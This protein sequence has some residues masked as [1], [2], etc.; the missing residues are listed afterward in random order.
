MISAVANRAAPCRTRSKNRRSP[1]LPGLKIALRTAHGSRPLRINLP[2]FDPGGPLGIILTLFENYFLRQR[3]AFVKSDSAIAGCDCSSPR[4]QTKQQTKCPTGAYQKIEKIVMK[5]T[6]LF[7]LAFTSFAIA[8]QA[9]SKPKSSAKQTS[10]KSEKTVTSEEVNQSANG[11]S[12]VKG[13]W[14][15]PDGYKF[16]KGQVLRTTAKTGKAAPKATRKARAGE[17]R[18]ADSKDRS[19]YARQNGGRNGSRDQAKK[20]GDPAG[21]ANRI[22]FVT[23]RG[24]CP[25]SATLLP[26]GNIGVLPHSC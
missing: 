3:N 18:K 7:L 23:A 9:S 2:I 8:H 19:P 15:H 4:N 25:C 6:L 22:A 11:W 14:I 24:V 21:A 12:Y 5:R 26:P 1:P 17:C 16:V 20:P 10:T 13:E